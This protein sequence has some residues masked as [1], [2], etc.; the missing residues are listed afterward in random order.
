MNQLQQMKCYVLCHTYV[1]VC[2]CVCVCFCTCRAP[3]TIDQ[4]LCKWLFLA[5]NAIARILQNSFLVSKAAVREV[6]TA[7]MMLCGHSVGCCC[8][9][10][11]ISNGPIIWFGEQVLKFEVWLESFS[12]LWSSWAPRP[13]SLH[14]FVPGY[15]IW[16][17]STTAALR[18][19][20]AW[21][22]SY[23]SC[24]LQVLRTIYSV[25]NN[26]SASAPKCCQNPY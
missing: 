14:I 24:Y 2:V 17:P 16:N 7:M 15:L 10:K 25:G 26:V 3:E 8:F 6:L 4:K 1:C 19:S 20:L 22:W 21:F 13:R 12:S 11:C 5:A 9:S 23:C 18:I